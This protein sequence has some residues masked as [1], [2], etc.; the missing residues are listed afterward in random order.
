MTTR[1]GSGSLRDHLVR[2]LPTGMP[3]I[4]LATALLM[5]LFW[6]IVIDYTNDDAFISFR[7]AENLLDGHGLVFNPGA[8]VEGY[9]NFLWTILIASTMAIGIDPVVSCRI[10]G[11][12]LG[13]GTVLLVY[14]FGTHI[15]QRTPAQATVAPLLLAFSIPF[16]I[17]TFSGLETPLFGFL[18]LLGTFLFILEWR[19]PT[20]FPLSS[21]FFALSALTRPEGVLLFAISFLAMGWRFWFHR[22]D[23]IIRG[24]RQ[25]ALWALFFLAIYGFYFVWRYSY[26]GYPFPNTY[27][28]RQPT[29]WEQRLA[30]W[31]RGYTYVRDFAATNGGVLFLL[32]ALLLL[33]TRVGRWPLYVGAL[34]LSWAAYLV[35]VGG[36][37]KVFFRL[38][39]LILPLLFLLVQDGVHESIGVISILTRTR[40]AFRLGLALLLVTIIVTIDPFLLRDQVKRYMREANVIGPQRTAIGHWLRQ[41]AS[42]DATLA[43]RAAGI[44]PFYSGL[45]TIDMLGVS[46]PRIAHQDILDADRPTAHGKT[47]VDYITSLR[48]DYI[49]LTTSE[50]WDE[51]REINWAAYG[52]DQVRLTGAA[53]K[54][55]HAL[56]RLA[57]SQP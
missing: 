44:V 7:Y 38:V 55:P 3:G 54:G 52:Y 5:M 15:A 23:A 29:S 37:Q 46:D 41:N 48:P 27:Y 45:Y 24:G 10:L 17:W 11:L 30:H 50:T 26:Y 8:R 2:T 36:D 9:T 57:D 34:A 22:S 35:Y 21:I 39:T 33:R 19:D 4:L 1:H 53:A 13:L 51:F 16:V 32:P 14:H 49:M 6:F 25:F 28:V 56:W 31:E 42:S 12:V 47:D 43:V 18:A 40:S 20:R